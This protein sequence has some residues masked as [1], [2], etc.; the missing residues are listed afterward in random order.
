LSFFVERTFPPNMNP[1]IFAMT[2]I[3]D[4][5]KHIWRNILSDRGHRYVKHI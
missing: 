3:S 5:E 4:K 1:A 2:K